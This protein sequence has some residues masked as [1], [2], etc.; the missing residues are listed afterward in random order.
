[1][2]ADDGKPP[3]LA[4]PSNELRLAVTKH[5][6]KLNVDSPRVVCFDV[7]VKAFR[8][9]DVSIV[10]AVRNDDAGIELIALKPG[11]TQVEVQTPENGTIVLLASAMAQDG[12][13]R[14]TGIV[15]L[16]QKM[17][18]KPQWKRA[19]FRTPQKT[20]ET[21]MWALREHD[22]DC[23]R[24]CFSDPDKMEPIEF[25]NEEDLKE[26]GGVAS[27]LQFLAIRKVN[28]RTVDLKF[29]VVGWGDAPLSHRLKKVGDAWKLDSSSSTVNADW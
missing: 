4:Q 14:S 23:I 25:Q 9:R 5:S 15:K 29:S 6:I 13:H 22:S 1:M 26:A 17:S 10:K 20:A 27:G 11:A 8:S 18:P 12:E 16:S 21:F 19:G 7:P 3:A 2:S 28:E 24:S